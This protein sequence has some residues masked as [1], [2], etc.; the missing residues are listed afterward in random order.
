MSQATQELKHVVL[1]LH[2]HKGIFAEDKVE[3]HMYSK[4]IVMA[5]LNLMWQF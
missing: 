3:T 5:S 4:Y 1:V 2:T